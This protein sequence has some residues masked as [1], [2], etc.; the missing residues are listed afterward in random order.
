MAKLR[1]SSRLARLE[2]GSAVAEFALLALP[3]S[4]LLVGGVN[5][6]LNVF[7][8]SAFRFE[9]ISVARFAALAD[10]SIQ[11]ASDR[12]NQVCSLAMPKLS[13]ICAVKFVGPGAGFSSVTFS[14][15][16]LNLAVLTA[17]RVTI[18]AV[19]PLEIPK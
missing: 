2:R 4:L 15:Q 12:A 6:C 9:A 8:D 13:A 1:P 5:Y 3:M 19:V 18:N 14:Y 11:Q 10:V 17:E 7:I 16:P